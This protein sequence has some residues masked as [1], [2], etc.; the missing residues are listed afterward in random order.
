[1]KNIVNTRNDIINRPIIRRAMANNDLDNNILTTENN[2]PDYGS[3][4]ETDYY[5]QNNYFNQS[6]SVSM[7][8]SE[9]NNDE[10]NMNINR[11]Q[12]LPKTGKKINMYNSKPV[13]NIK[14]IDNILNKKT[15]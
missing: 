9:L 4:E 14:S 7:F 3:R 6:Y 12:S 10:G 5:E 8:S 1:M 15:H 2:F 13:S 11:E